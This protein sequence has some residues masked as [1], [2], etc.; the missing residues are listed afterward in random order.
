MVVVAHSRTKSLLTHSTYSLHKHRPSCLS[1]WSPTS[2]LPSPL[3]IVA[4]IPRPP[5]SGSV[6]P[7]S[8]F[9]Y[10]ACL[11]WFCLASIRVVFAACS[12]IWSFD[13]SLRS[14][15][16]LCPSALRL[17][18]CLSVG[19]L[20]STPL[21]LLPL[22]YVGFSSLFLAL[23]RRLEVRGSVLSGVF[24][25]NR[26]SRWVTFALSRLLLLLP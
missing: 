6:Y 4:A 9:V 11:F 17:L 26:F 19:F 2:P 21:C 16:W 5:V 3:V 1:F 15:L 22:L 23:L 25:S 13:L 20:W 14:G 12:G 8:G 18:I 7:F 24:K 10:S